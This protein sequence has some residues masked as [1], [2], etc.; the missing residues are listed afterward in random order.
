MQKKKNQLLTLSIFIACV[1]HAQKNITGNLTTLSGKPAT[2]SSVMLIGIPDEKIIRTSYSSLKG[3]F[4]FQMVPKGT[5]YLLVKKRFY[6]SEKSK[7]ITI[8][9]NDMLISPIRIILR[10]YGTCKKGVIPYNSD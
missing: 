10:R 4:D 8:D 7:I 9:E 2:K 1:I 5:Y 6:Y 3:E